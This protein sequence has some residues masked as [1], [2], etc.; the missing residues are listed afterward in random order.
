MLCHI[1]IFYPYSSNFRMVVIR[2][3]QWGRWCVSW[4]AQLVKEF[5][6]F[7]GTWRFHYYVHKSWPLDSFWVPVNIGFKIYTFYEHYLHYNWNTGK[8]FIA[9]TSLWSK[10]YSPIIWIRWVWVHNKWQFFF[11]CAE[12][13]CRLEDLQCTILRASFP[14][15]RHH[16]NIFHSLLPNFS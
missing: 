9:Y 5:P 13:D 4:P 12:Q 3:M 16:P 6:T 8:Q 11:F 1:H 14:I 10:C 2:A 15:V 7:Y